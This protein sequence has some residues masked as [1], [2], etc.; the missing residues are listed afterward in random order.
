MRIVS[1]IKRK[2]YSHKYYMA[3][4][5]PVTAIPCDVCGIMF[6]PNTTLHK[7][8][9]K[10][11]RLKFAEI[12]YKN[13]TNNYEKTCAECGHVF[14]QKHGFLCQ[15]CKDKK[16][17]KKCV[18]CGAS[19]YSKESKSSICS[20]S[21]RREY[22]KLKVKRVCSYCESEFYENRH[23]N[24]VCPD[25]S[26]ELLANRSVK[27]NHNYRTR[28]VGAFVESVDARVV[29]ESDNYVCQKCGKKT[30][31]NKPFNHNDYPN[32]DHIVPLSK[33][34]KHEYKNVQCLCRLCNITKSGK[35]I[36]QMRLF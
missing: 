5:N 26:R 22:M 20:V 9:G 13:K 14:S 7:I 11:C 28:K 34:G 12:N 10:E 23:G 4:K 1:T 21:C 31:R 15:D 29:F 33:G 19:F 25:C 32:L 24:R 16:Y 36:G 17:T 2:E 6:V 3:H 35:N 30:T 18:V 8:C 27:R